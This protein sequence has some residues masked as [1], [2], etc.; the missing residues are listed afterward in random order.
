ML[1]ALAQALPSLAD[2]LEADNAEWDA[3]INKG[4]GPV[5]TVPF[6]ADA[7]LAETQE[8][9]P[10]PE[11][12]DKPKRGRPAKAKKDEPAPAIRATPEDRKPADEPDED[13]EEP[14]TGEIVEEDDD[15]KVYT[16]DDVKAALTE[17]ANKF[18]MAEASS[19]GP[20]L[21]GAPRLSAIDDNPDAFKKATLALLEAVN[22]G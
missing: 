21:M 10:E 22:N 13:K 11:V 16:R 14:L 4:K 15:G 18:G 9:A 7:A 2:A 5:R 6:D 19:R 1:R 3:R 20:K 12:E 8:A 17:F